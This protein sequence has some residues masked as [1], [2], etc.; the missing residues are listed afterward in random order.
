MAQEYLSQ[1]MHEQGRHVHPG[2]GEQTHISLFEGRGACQAIAKAQPHAIVFAR[3]RI[4]DRAQVGFAHVS[5]RLREKPIVEGAL[6]SAGF[7]NRREFG[8]QEK[9]LQELIGDNE[10]AVGIGF[11]QTVAAR[12]PEFGHGANAAFTTGGLVACNVR[13]GTERSGMARRSAPSLSCQMRRRS[14]ARVSPLARCGN[15][16]IGVEPHLATEPDRIELGVT[17]H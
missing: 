8:A 13:F 2:A 5:A 1:L 9:T 7:E 10:P 14:E 15:A 17:G 16:A 3:I 4:R 6:C 11:E 12:G